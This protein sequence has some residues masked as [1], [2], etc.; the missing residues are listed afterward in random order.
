MSIDKPKIVIISGFA[1]TVGIPVTLKFME[2]GY[3]IIGIDSFVNRVS[4]TN[5]FGEFDDEKHSDRFNRIF[6]IELD[7]QRI[8]IE[9]ILYS[10]NAYNMHRDGGFGRIEDIDCIIH[11]AS[12]ASPLAYKAMPIYTIESNVEGTKRLLEIAHICRSRKFVFA[13]TSEIYG[14]LD[15]EWFKEE[16][17]GLVTAYGP[18]SQYDCSKM[19]GEAL[20]KSYQ[21]NMNAGI[22]RI[23][24]TYSEWGGKDDGRVVNNFISRMLE[25]KDIEIFG[26]GNQTRAFQYASDLADGIFKYAQSDVI[27]PVNLGNPHEYCSVNELKYTIMQL[28]K[29]EYGISV[30]SHT[31][32]KEQMDKDD[33]RIRRPDITKAKE[34]LGWE[35]KV[36]LKEGLKKVIERYMKRAH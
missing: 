2:E 8:N 9:D 29:D 10:L 11:L 18:R 16:D 12:P 20:V 36:T 30:T 4:R 19:C 26:S 33:P 22:V 17:A 35:P 25:N 21:H 27:E 6:N 31:I 23:F 24:N 3:N 7:V 34:L 5:C 32:Y 1:G 15:K 14:K 13:S 28:L